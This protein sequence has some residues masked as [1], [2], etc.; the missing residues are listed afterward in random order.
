[1]PVEASPLASCLYRGVVRHRRRHRF[2]HEFRYQVFFNYLDLDELDRVFEGRWLWS[3]RRASVARFQRA[4]YLGDAARPLA[5]CVRDAV[6]EKLGTRPTGPIR[7]LTNLRWW[8]YIQNPISLYYC[9]EEA[10]ESVTAV[11]AEVTNTPW[12]DRHSYVLPGPAPDERV[13][14]YTGDKELH[15]SPFFPM[16]MTYHWRLSVPGDRLSVH[17][18]NRLDDVSQ[19]DAALLLERRPITTRT[20]AGTIARH[21]FITGQVLAG[22]YWQA[23]RLWWKG[24]EFCPHP[25]YRSAI[26]NTLD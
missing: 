23:V 14:R 22:I 8:G 17:I 4:D 19:F 11:V 12:G 7:L 10:G 15:V 1:M 26:V 9:F 25:R 2:A 20:L 5:D 16:E 24:A 3:T 13:W 6:A 18:E 21:P